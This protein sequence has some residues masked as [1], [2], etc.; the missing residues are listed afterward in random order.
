MNPNILFGFLA[1]LGGCYWVWWKFHELEKERHLLLGLLSGVLADHPQALE[2]YRQTLSRHELM[3]S[4][5][6]YKAGFEGSKSEMDRQIKVMR[7]AVS[8]AEYVRR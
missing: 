4:S 2:E 3:G 1:I 5:A 7:S 8:L 6:E